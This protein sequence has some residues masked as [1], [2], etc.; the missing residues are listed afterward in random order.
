MVLPLA[1]GISDL[2]CSFSICVR[3]KSKYSLG[4]PTG[5]YAGALRPIAFQSVLKIFSGEYISYLQQ[6][7]R[8]GLELFSE[9]SVQYPVLWYARFP[10]LI[11]VN[12]CVRVV[13]AC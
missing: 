8:G 12:L 6:I 10:C 1:L 7:Y 11:C 13:C 2:V 5:L 4:R 3:L 9:L